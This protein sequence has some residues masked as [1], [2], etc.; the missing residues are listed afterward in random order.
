M[1]QSYNHNATETRLKRF[2]KKQKV[3][4]KFYLFIARIFILAAF[5]GLGYLIYALLVTYEVIK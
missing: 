3:I 5:A 1:T 2:E 4:N